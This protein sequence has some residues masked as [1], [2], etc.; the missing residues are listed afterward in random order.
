MSQ[1][2]TH[3][4][5]RIGGEAPRSVAARRWRSWR[6]PVI[7][8]VVVL[9]SAGL[10]ALIQPTTSSDPLAVDNPQENGV[11]AL[12]QVLGAQGVQ[13]TEV[14]DVASAVERARA[15]TTLAVAGTSLLTP[16]E[17]DELAATEADLVLI[18]PDYIALDTLTG[19]LVTDGWSWSESTRT[20]TCPDP[21]A[22]AAGTISATD[23]GLRLTGR[24]TLCF[25]GPDDPGVGSYAVVE[26]GGRTVRVLADSTL[27]TNATVA[28]HGNAALGLRMLGHH[29]QLTWLRPTLFGLV[30]SGAVGPSLWTLLP[31]AAGPVAALLALAATVAAIWRARALGRVATEPLPVTVRA[32]E[33][34]RGRG[35]LYRRARSRGHAAAALR[36]AAARRMAARLGLPHSADATTLIG[37]VASAT[38]RSTGEVSGLLYGPPPTDD[39]GLLG[40]TRLLDQLE[41]EVHRT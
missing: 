1:T 14:E 17:I 4:P 27:L 29:D 5:V 2:T 26:V 13:V 3:A 8:A 24:G 10:A 34:T 19:G 11:R 36:A 23:Y 40:L 20:A 38:G 39:D 7:I 21:D 22:T 35:R 32:A 28:E 33:T 9:A 25:P 15:G 31:P 12:M 30:G 37:A 6:L 16:E 41:S 18:D